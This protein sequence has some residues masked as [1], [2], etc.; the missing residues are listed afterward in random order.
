[1][2]AAVGSTHT[3]PAGG[4]LMTHPP[5][6]CRQSLKRPRTPA[7]RSTARS[8]TAASRLRRK[9]PI[10]R[11]TRHVLWFCGAKRFPAEWA[12]VT[13]ATSGDDNPLPVLGTCLAT[14]PTTGK[15]TLAA[16]PSSPS[17]GRYE[18]QPAW[19]A[20]CLDC[21]EAIP[22][23][24]GIICHLAPDHH[25]RAPPPPPP[26]TS[27]VPSHWISM[28]RLQRFSTANLFS[29]FWPVLPQWFWDAS[30]TRST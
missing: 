27:S 14:L 24:S 3:G 16:P 20:L 4:V 8:P 10:R 5:V 13:N 7:A 19:V 22:A 21:G 15:Y 11:T 23:L 9:R 6:A 28:P 12:R 29:F 2:D 17:G 1:M 18:A 25:Y 30:L 26:K